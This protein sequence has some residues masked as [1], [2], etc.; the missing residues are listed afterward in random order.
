MVHDN[1]G[2]IRANK[3]VKDSVVLDDL[4]RNLNITGNANKIIQ[5]I[6]L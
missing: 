3:T 1:V 6:F 4:K 2:I 5:C